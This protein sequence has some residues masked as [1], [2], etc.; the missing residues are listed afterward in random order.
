MRVDDD[1]FV[2]VEGVAEN[3]IGGLAPDPGQRVQLRHRL[4]DFAF[5]LFLDR[6]GRGANA[7]GFVPKKSGRLD[8]LLQ[9]RRRRG[10]EMPPPSDNA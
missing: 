6:G 9:F 3:D 2:D 8:G 5:V 7:F 10:R 1:A 4:R